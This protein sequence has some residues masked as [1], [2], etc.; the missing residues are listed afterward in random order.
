M[1]TLNGAAPDNPRVAMS[2]RL[3]RRLEEVPEESDHP[4]GSFQGHAGARW[5][6]LP[7]VHHA[8]GRADL[9]S[10]R[11][12][13][14]QLINGEAPLRGFGRFAAART[15]RTAVRVGPGEAVV[16]ERLPTQD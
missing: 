12:R 13:S 3:V 16:I 7:S 8:S 4:H 1:A 5:L 11:F 10:S 15:V 14:P 6:Q 9:F 2:Q